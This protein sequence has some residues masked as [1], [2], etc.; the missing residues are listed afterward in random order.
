MFLTDV[1]RFFRG[2]VRLSVSGGSTERFLNLAGRAGVALWH[3]RAKNGVLYAS[4]YARSYKRLRGPAKKSGVRMRLVKKRGVPFKL[5]RYRRRK[6]ILVGTVLFFA[7]LWFFS[8]FVWTVDIRGN[9]RV[10]TEEITGVL[11]SL[12]VRPG[13]FRLT[14]N[15]QK[16]ENEAL[17]QMP[18]LSWLAINLKGSTAYVEVK[19]RIYPPELVPVDRPCNVKA[20]E[21]GQI[22][23]LEP[24]D[25]M[26]LVRVH[27]TVK[28]GDI[29]VSGV[30]EEKTG[31][32]RLVHARA[33]VIA[34]TQHELSE[35]VPFSQQ[36]QVFTGKTVVRRELL[37]AQLTVPLSFGRAPQGSYVQSSVVQNAAIFG[38]RL[39]VSVRT[40]TY[41]EYVL[42]TVTLTKEQAL[43]E[44]K[45]KLA[46]QEKLEFA[47]I[48]V[49]SKKYQSMQ[50][51]KGVTCSGSYSCEENIAYEEEIKIS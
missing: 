24:Y 39:P 30:V 49:I 38:L 19:E 51:A 21:T 14:I 47:D 15:L 4:T 2:S 10:S 12:G 3:I 43:A 13:A 8:C 29:V 41:R 36:K 6:G 44:A 28:K 37:A 32:S 5:F 1:L 35:T 34:L 22:I 25:G 20:A 16:V 11:S 48:K 26:P 50:D 45:T 9:S 17:I 23:K 7:V 31:V 33:K 40:S 46:A 42:K 18:D 27:D